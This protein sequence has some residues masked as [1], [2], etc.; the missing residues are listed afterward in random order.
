MYISS[1]ARVLT[2]GSPWSLSLVPFMQRSFQKGGRGESKRNQKCVL[3]KVSKIR[4]EYSIELLLT[5]SEQVSV[6]FG[7]LVLRQSRGGG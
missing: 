6:K 7:V 1:D 3:K 4:E 2:T 5:S